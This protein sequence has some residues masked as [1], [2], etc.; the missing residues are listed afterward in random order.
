MLSSLLTGSTDVQKN[1]LR[2]ATNSPKNINEDELLVEL[3]ETLLKIDIDNPL[4]KLNET[5]IKDNNGG[6]IE[7]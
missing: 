4:A 3:V 6:R 1:E 7:L 2:T 5:T